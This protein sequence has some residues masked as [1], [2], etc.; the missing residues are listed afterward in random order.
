MQKNGKGI[1]ISFKYL[2]TLYKSFFVLPSNIWPSRSVLA[3]KIVEFDFP[4]QIGLL[5][6]I[7]T[8]TGYYKSIF[9]NL[10]IHLS[11]LAF[12]A[13]CAA[14][15]AFIA[16]KLKNNEIMKELTSND[17]KNMKKIFKSH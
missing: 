7:K 9:G 13:K 3:F 11:N 8:A 4:A 12:L 17:P 6:I 14:F 2:Y 16:L 1:D 10:S 5:G 15:L